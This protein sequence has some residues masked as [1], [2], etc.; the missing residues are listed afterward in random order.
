MPALHDL[1]PERVSA[2]LQ[3]RRLGHPYVFFDRIGSTND[4]VREYAATGAAEGLVVAADEQTAGRGRLDRRWWAPP[5]SGLL[6]SLLLR[7][8][9]P[10]SQAMQLTMC[11]GLGAVEGVEAVTGLQPALKWPNDLLLDGR[12]L[13]GMLS[14]IHAGDDDVA[15][16]VLGLG[17]N[18][19]LDLSGATHGLPPDVAASAASLSDVLGAPADRSVLLAHILLHCELWLDHLDQPAVLHEAWT[20]RLDTL[21]RQVT[22][23]SAT[24]ILY[25]RAVGV[26]PSGALLVQDQRGETLTIWSGDVSSLRD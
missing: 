24:G 1:A 3:T 8:R 12:K 16:A 25:G 5:G 17:L 21:G 9:L 26:T 23:T 14:E 15:F 13:G 7:P 6:M 19:N 20:A 4:A 22:V 10:L 18:V 11:L 2:L